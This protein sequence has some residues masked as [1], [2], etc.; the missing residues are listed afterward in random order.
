MEGW[1]IFLIVVVVLILLA[2]GIKI[3]KQYERGN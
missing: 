2:T 3:V 1:V